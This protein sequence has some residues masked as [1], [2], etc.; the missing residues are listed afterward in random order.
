MITKNQ[1]EKS[2]IFIKENM[3]G[4]V[5]SSYMEFAKL[6]SN[7][8]DY[9]AAEYENN[10]YQAAMSAKALTMGSTD[11][12]ALAKCLI[13]S[14]FNGNDIIN[15]IL[16]DVCKNTS[17]SR[18]DSS[19]FG[20]GCEIPADEAFY[21]KNSQDIY[22][23]LTAIKLAVT[24]FTGFDDI[25]SNYVYQKF[26]LSKIPICITIC[27]ESFRF[28][29]SLS[30]NRSLREPHLNG[31]DIEDSMGVSTILDKLSSVCNVDINQLFACFLEN[32]SD[33]IREKGDDEDKKKSPD[34]GK[35]FFATDDNSEDAKSDSEVS[36]LIKIAKEAMDPDNSELIRGVIDSVTDTL[37]ASATLTYLIFASKIMGAK[38]DVFGWAYKSFIK[39]EMNHFDIGNY[40]TAADVAGFT[41]KGVDGE[42]SFDARYSKAGALNESLSEAHIAQ[43]SDYTR[44]Q[45]AFVYRN[46]KLKFS[47]WSAIVNALFA[48]TNFHTSSGGKNG[49]VLESDDIGKAHNITDCPFILLNNKS[50]PHFNALYSSARTALVQ[51]LRCK[52]RTYNTTIQLKKNSDLPCSSNA[53]IK[54]VVS[55]I[56]DE[57]AKT[58]LR[59]C[60]GIGKNNTARSKLVLNDILL[61]HDAKIETILKFN[62][63]ATTKVGNIFLRIAYLILMNYTHINMGNT[64]SQKD[65]ITGKTWGQIYDE[66]YYGLAK[67]INDEL[68][69]YG[70][71]P[72]FS[73][74]KIDYFDGRVFNDCLTLLTPFLKDR[75]DSK[76]I[77]G[78]GYE[79]SCRNTFF[80]RFSGKIVNYKFSMLSE[81]KIPEY[82]KKIDEFIKNKENKY[83]IRNLGGNNLDFVVEDQSD[84]PYISEC[85]AIRS[86]FNFDYGSLKENEIVLQNP[87]NADGS[88]FPKHRLLS[89]AITRLTPT[90]DRTFL[91]L[92]SMDSAISTI[93]S[94]T[95]VGLEGADGMANN[96]CYSSLGALGASVHSIDI[97]N[98]MYGN[99]E[100]KKPRYVVETTDFISPLGPTTDSEGN[101]TGGPETAAIDQKKL[102]SS[103]SS[104][105][106]DKID[107]MIII[108]KRKELI[109]RYNT[110]FNR[111]IAN[112]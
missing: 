22:A 3:P 11:I 16:S 20:K 76:S 66:I 75:D 70:K 112:S 15:V 29:E 32:L 14:N 5:R 37:I 17:T 102:T 88:I 35:Y 51:F 98:E 106:F 7:V 56:H 42:G 40:P 77:D 41:G 2:V 63:S 94:L 107:D 31:F 55:L 78:F 99:D 79:S 61:T 67:S 89:E 9:I 39:D 44:Q 93:E 18:D 33:R 28:T 86:A 69:M 92:E 48:T 103:E 111:L 108:K 110:L 71:F 57:E 19:M 105:S 85:Y 82:F 13:S 91:S 45:K 25:N 26:G 101:I 36:R 68:R 60:I 34:F 38:P 6:F 12:I 74:V 58:A 83:R 59:N 64:I 96:S 24:P 21:I 30:K 46:I 62:E 49:M 100:D 50:G 95:N 97:T 72:S 73:S 8:A 80:G 87:V 54:P 104:K 43:D 90:M 52:Y 47:S 10:P 4:F 53:M 65:P 81:S 109:E 27:D 23:P 1:Y 84:V